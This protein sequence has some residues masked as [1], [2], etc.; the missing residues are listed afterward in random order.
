MKKL[1]YLSKGLLIFA[2]SLMLVSCHTNSYYKCKSAVDAYESHNKKA[3]NL[4]DLQLS[5]GSLID[6]YF[7]G[8][9]ADEQCTIRNKVHSIENM[10][11]L[12]AE[13]LSVGT[14]LIKN[15]ET[16][17]EIC[18]LELS[19][20]K[21]AKLYKNGVLYKTARWDIEM[22]LNTWIGSSAYIYVF[23]GDHFVGNYD[24]ELNI[25]GREMSAVGH[26]LEE[27]T[28]SFHHGE[29]FEKIK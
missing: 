22:K 14:Y 4:F 21:Q 23:E 9:T 7:D 11:K 13:E 12:K 2:V 19:S 25:S 3:Q 18:K 26:Y 10:I 28:G 6:Q 29:V 24:I 1:L 5:Y 15:K 27:M 8:C 16:G 17:I 20:G